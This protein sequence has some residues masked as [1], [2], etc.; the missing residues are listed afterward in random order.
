MKELEHF[1]VCKVSTKRFK[2]YEMQNNAIETR[3]KKDMTTN[4]RY[5]EKEEAT[6]V[7]MVVVVA[8]EKKAHE[9]N[10]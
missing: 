2:W 7:A 1:A 4:E 10:R 6:T 5:W 8:Y 9:I 3:E